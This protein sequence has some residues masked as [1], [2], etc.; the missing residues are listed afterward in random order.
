MR[1]SNHPSFTANLLFRLRASRVHRQAGESDRALR[2]TGSYRSGRSRILSEVIGKSLLY[3][4]DLLIYNLGARWLLEG[5]YHGQNVVSGIKKRRSNARGSYRL[6][7]AVARS[8]YGNISIASQQYIELN[9]RGMIFIT[10]FILLS[11]I[12]H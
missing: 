6:L 2:N 8:G 7:D 9:Y 4:S 10:F 5:A 11:N 1:D 3:R 12:T